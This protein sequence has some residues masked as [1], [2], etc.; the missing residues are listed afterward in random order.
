MAVKYTLLYEVDMTKYDYL[1]SSFQIPLF[2]LNNKT[3]YIEDDPDFGVYHFSFD[4]KQYEFYD[5]FAP[6]FYLGVISDGSTTKLYINGHII[7][8]LKVASDDYPQSFKNGRIVKFCKDVKTADELYDWQKV[9]LKSLLE[10]NK[11]IYF[12]HIYPWIGGHTISNFLPDNLKSAEEVGAKLISDKNGCVAIDQP[13]NYISFYSFKS[14]YSSCLVEY[15]F[16]GGKNFELYTCRPPSDFK[17]VGCITYKEY[18]KQAKWVEMRNVCGGGHNVFDRGNFLR[19]NLQNLN[20]PDCD[21]YEPH[22]IETFLAITIGQPGSSLSTCHAFLKCIKIDFT[23]R[24]KIEEHTIAED[25][26]VGQNTWL[27][28]VVKLSNPIPPTTYDRIKD[29]DAWKGT[30]FEGILSDYFAVVFPDD[31]VKDKKVVKHCDNYAGGRCN[32]SGNFFTQWTMKLTDENI[33]KLKDIINKHISTF[34]NYCDKDIDEY[35]RRPTMTDVN[36]NTN[37]NTGISFNVSVTDIQANNFNVITG[38][39]IKFDK[40]SQC[41]IHGEKIIVTSISQ[42]RISGN[43]I[44]AEQSANANIDGERIVIS[45]VQKVQVTGQD[46]IVENSEK[47]QV[48]GEKNKVN[49]ASEASINGK[50][51]KLSKGLNIKIEGNANDIENSSNIQ[52]SGD[53]NKIID[54]KDS[55]VF[56]KDNKLNNLEGVFVIG[57]GLEITSS[58]LE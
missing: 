54:T 8:D 52:I 57:S 21:E 22:K 19:D 5:A 42:S 28:D 29:A 3:L 33:E 46:I 11:E 17:I 14:G 35:F 40:V 32:Q 49:T 55:K 25:I 18:L 24:E 41:V 39:K 51:N 26:A 31:L 7:Y 38:Q 48:I 36:T 15:T 16:S 47:V 2:R 56:G 13:T 1:N 10:Q 12:G 20:N 45:Q 23:T 4:G 58:E 53:N 27:Y 9:D 43:N 44:K 50:Q 6:H 37:T 34:K 30:R